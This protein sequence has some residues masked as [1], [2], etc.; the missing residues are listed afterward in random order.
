MDIETWVALPAVL[1]SAAA[2]YFTGR[3]T[4]AAS[5]QTKIQRQLRIDA[6]QPY[7]WVDL[8]ADDATGTLV[9]LVIGNSGPTVATNVRITIDPP[10]VA[11]DE[12]K[13]RTDTAQ[14]QLAE[15]IRSLAPGRVLTW[16]LGQGFNLLRDEGRHTYTFTI[17]ADGPFGQ[18]PA[19]SYPVDLSDLRGTL[20]RPAGS[21]HQ[22]TLAV[23][24]LTNEIATSRRTEAE[25]EDFPAS[26]YAIVSPV[27]VGYLDAPTRPSQSWGLRRVSRLAD[28]PV[29]VYL[30]D[31]QPQTVDAIQSALRT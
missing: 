26:E 16:P 15:G 10:L 27:G 18:V 25:D 6:A 2:L 11:I 21:L 30:A 31:G 24:K 17:T 22:L 7:V 14:A 12:L 8:R 29:S 4:R 3:A 28:L 5:E 1:I 23:K 13:S 20:D 19:M 9:N